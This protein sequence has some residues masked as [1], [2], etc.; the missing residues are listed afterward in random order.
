MLDESSYQI[1]GA[2]LPTLLT[3]GSFS[4]HPSVTITEDME[5][6]IS[7]KT[8]VDI[9]IG[10]IDK[11]L[12]KN[13]IRNRLYFLNARTGSGKSTTFIYHLFDKFIR[14]KG[15]QMFVT[16]PRV[17]LCESNANEIVRWSER[18]DRLGDTVGFLTGP[19]KEYCNSS[20]GRLYY[21]TPQILA[22]HLVGCLSAD[23][24]EN[25]ED[26][27]PRILV[28]DEA[29]LLDMPTLETLS[30]LY[31]FLVR[32]KDSANC[33]LIIFASATINE[34]DFIRYFGQLLEKNDDEV[35]TDFLSDP[36][37]CG[38]VSGS[39]NFDVSLNY[40]DQDTVK[41]LF[42]DSCVPDK[43]G[44]MIQPKDKN[45]AVIHFSN[46]IAKFIF[47]NYYEKIVERID[48]HHK[49]NDFLMF[50]PKKSIIRMTLKALY[51]LIRA[52]DKE[53][54]FLIEGET[55][56][57]MVED[58]RT[59]A[60]NIAEGNAPRVLLVGYSRGYSQASDEVLNNL[61]PTVSERKIFITTPIIETGKTIPTLRWCFDSGLELKPCPNP[62]VYNP[63]LFSINLKVVPINKS[64]ATQR[65][66]R[67]GREQPGECLRL[68]TESVY[69]KLL[70]EEL[71]ET[72][73][74]YC[75][76]STFTSKFQTMDR[77]IYYDMFNNN[78]YL[79]RISADIMLRSTIDLIN[80]GFFTVFSYIIGGVA[81]AK[82]SHAMICYTQ[83]L[84]YVHRKS[85]FESLLLVIINLKFLSN[86]LTPIALN[87]D[88]LPFQI[89]IVKALPRI[90]LD[91]FAAIKLARNVITLVQYEP[92]FR[93][94]R[95]I[96]D[97]LF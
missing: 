15:H 2:G 11:K 44:Q 13:G 24:S 19:K 55:K 68:Y 18:G 49:G 8:A 96:Y 91:L 26:L 57:Q 65:L 37:M 9:I 48:E 90:D 33:P 10:I 87:P 56:Y 76:S 71:P 47:D 66:G 83:Q 39:A 20:S 46:T 77:W 41:K 38:Y 70:P 52:R 25:V 82:I 67:V 6:E 12:G 31:D 1:T 58:W 3:K 84:Y 75:L 69:E 62:L 74:N 40:L 29:H 51:D 73:N 30:T 34:K 81:H 86:D 78:N 36:S 43:T 50:V 32:F 95:N 54:V 35:I 7:L 85:L 16:E 28:I 79:H 5:K 17:P 42:D 4:Y 14:G 80:S 23:S 97:R 94:F 27:F 61:S 64:A 89:H 59:S 60:M 22:N 93:T 88:R 21:M 72:I 92:S 63:Y 45:E 53:K